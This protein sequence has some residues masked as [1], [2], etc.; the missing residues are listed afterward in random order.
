M[1]LQSCEHKFCLGASID[2]VAPPCVALRKWGKVWIFTHVGATVIVASKRQSEFASACWDNFIKF[3][4]CMIVLPEFLG[5]SRV[6]GVPTGIRVNIPDYRFKTLTPTDVQ[7]SR[8]VLSPSDSD[9]QAAGNIPRQ[10]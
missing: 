4:L 3:I 2:P 1:L 6:F 7:P 10:T 8:I 9:G 5:V